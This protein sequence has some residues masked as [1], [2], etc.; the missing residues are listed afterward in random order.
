MTCP[1]CKLK[2]DRNTIIEQF[3]TCYVMFS[4]PRLVSGHLLVIPKRHIAKLS[5]LNIKEKKELVNTTIKYQEKI[6][7]YYPGTQIKQ[8]Y[9]PFVPDGK[10]KLTHLHIHIVPR[11][12]QDE[13]Y[14]K[15]LINETK[16]FK[17]LT[18]KESLEWIKKLK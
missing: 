13:I 9:M 17:E 11:E 7:K 5:E 15:A 6:L 18:K 14:T 2:T 3:E 1:F 10:L 4:N 8:N 12:N 16:L